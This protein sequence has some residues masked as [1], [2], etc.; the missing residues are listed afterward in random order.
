M[1]SSFFL[2]IKNAKMSIKRA[3]NVF[4]HFVLHEVLTKHDRLRVVV[5]LRCETDYF[6]LKNIILSLI[7]FSIN[8]CTKIDKLEDKLRKYSRLFTPKKHLKDYLKIRALD[9]PSIDFSAHRHSISYR[10]ELLRST[11]QPCLRS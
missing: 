5:P 4:A 6:R 2:K 7:V 11:T 9:S 10:T 3:I 8:I 1:T